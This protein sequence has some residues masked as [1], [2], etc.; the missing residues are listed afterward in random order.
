MDPLS[1]G[2]SCYKQ[3]DYQGALVAFTEASF[4]YVLNHNLSSAFP[5][6]SLCCSVPQEF[7]ISDAQKG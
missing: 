7:H 5:T 4:P 2:R 6:D 1:V 3:K